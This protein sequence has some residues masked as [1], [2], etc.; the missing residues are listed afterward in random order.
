[1]EKNKKF[2]QS[3][4]K[5]GV[6]LI[7]LAIF[8]F[9]SACS[10]TDL[11]TD[12]LTDV[13]EPP[14]MVNSDFENASQVLKNDQQ[15]YDNRANE[16]KNN[17]RGT[18]ADLTTLNN[19]MAEW[20][21]LQ[22][23][24]QTALNA[25]D[26]SNPDLTAFWDLNSQEDD[27]SSE[28]SDLFQTAYA[29]SNLANSVE[30]IKNNERQLKDIERSLKDINRNASKITP[31]PDTTELNNLVVQMKD[32]LSNLQ[33]LSSQASTTSDPETLSQDIQD[34]SNDFNGYT[35][36]FYSLQNDVND[37]INQANQLDNVSRN[38]KDKQREMKN[39]ER[40]IK[41]LSKDFGAENM[42][43]IQNG[44]NSMKEIVVQIEAAIAAKDGETA[45]DL[46]RDFWDLNS[47]VQDL[48]N[49]LNEA[50]NVQNQM[51]D[52]NRIIK[53]KT[54]QAKDMDRECK[55]A[56]CEG[57]ESGEKLNQINQLLTQMQQFATNND[58]DGFWDANSEYDS[59]NPEFWQL[60]QVKQSEK[61]IVR[62]LKDIAREIKDNQR[63]LN[64]LK[65]QFKR[66]ETVLTQA[67]I[68]EAENI[69]K[70][71]TVKA[72]ESK[73]KYDEGDYESARDAMSEAQNLGQD[74]YEISNRVN[75]Y[76]EEKYFGM[77]LEKIER[78]INNA[79]ITINDGLEEGSVDQE[80]ADLCLGYI[81]EARSYL[82]QM[83]E[84]QASGDIG[85]YKEVQIRFEDLGNKVD[86]D[87]GEF[88]S[89]DGG[90][91]YETYVNSYIDERLRGS[92][93]E[94]FDRI[95]EDSLDD[96]I[97][98]IIN[99]RLTEYMNP[100]FEKIGQFQDETARALEAISFI[101]NQ[102]QQELMSHKATM[103]ELIEQNRQ[104]NEDL[105]RQIAG[106]NYYGDAAGEL[107]Q[108]LSSGSISANKLKELENKARMAKFNDGVIPFMDTD[109]NEWYTR[110]VVRLFN[111]GVV[112]G[113]T[114]ESYAPGDFVS[115]AEILKMTLESADVGK[116]D[117]QP[118][119]GRDHWAAGYF[120][121]AENLGLTIVR[122]LRDP[123]RTATR[124]EV[125]RLILE[126]ADIHPDN[127][128]TSS[129]VDVAGN[130]PN[131]DYIETAKNFG[132]VSGDSG[133]GTFRPHDSVNRG[134]TAK[135]INNFIEFQGPDEGQGDEDYEDSGEDYELEE[136]S[137]EEVEPRF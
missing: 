82:E 15:N 128:S 129:F 95:S 62:Q 99:S 17:F 120:K 112:N 74:F 106:Y 41:R 50:S 94:I 52:A 45:N 77:E 48:I 133:R 35:Q 115:V 36:D 109:D 71:R 76:H 89:D 104:I 127:V 23:Q 126:V 119:F 58:F 31:A 80:K 84:V 118:S 81:T 116:A 98:N 117:G 34:L 8:L 67:D 69:L 49:N 102:Y 64:D 16:L 47:E 73:Q 12:T 61:D 21:T 97:S 110:Y 57:S 2:Y 39:K 32:I 86:K 122:G 121:Q 59:I 105:K 83:R 11:K 55:R 107:E 51:K 100:I 6:S 1:M 113:K 56:K 37:V 123:N 111:D 68:D 87:C 88:F 29:F 66:G 130:D 4:L 134:E 137:V 13:T 43:E 19:K 22:Q 125:V 18:K 5:F 93:E 91:G 28:V 65:R 40:E 70:Q 44:V 27:M 103:L 46:D 53:E 30:N 7:V 75:Q 124:G 132:I 63:F 78:E 25:V 131:K 26:S 54:R 14:K 3:K 20:S 96:M 72:E 101:S 85:S 114:K 10:S 135:I 90:P 79:E 42:Q 38:L 136:K 33:T 108:L 60:I 24:M 92:A 9:T